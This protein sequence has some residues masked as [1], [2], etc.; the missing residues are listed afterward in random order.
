MSRNGKLLHVLIQKYNL[1][2][3]NSSKVCSGVFTRTRQC[4]G[5]QEI[6]VVDYIFVTS[7]KYE[8]VRT[9]EIDEKNFFTSWRK[10]RKVR[11]FS[12]HHAIKVS[13]NLD[14]NRPTKRA[15]N[16]VVWNFDDPLNWKIFHQRTKISDDLQKAWKTKNN[17]EA[18]YKQ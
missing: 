14:F 11:R 3:P 4:N 10:L 16:V 2:L 13:L 18:C 15:K 8:Q 17:V 9:M 6:S 1:H 12:N 5:R 7:D